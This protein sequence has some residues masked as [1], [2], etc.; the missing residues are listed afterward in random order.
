MN[1][2]SIPDVFNLESL[3]HKVQGSTNVA[4]SPD[5]LLKISLPTSSTALSRL[6]ADLCLSPST[7]DPLPS[8]TS[9][10]SS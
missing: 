8:I 4:H 5:P 1:I 2:D 7:K 10:G 6:Y 9:H 3:R